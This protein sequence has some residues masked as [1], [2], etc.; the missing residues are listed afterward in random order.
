MNQLGFVLM[1]AGGPILWT[2]KK[3][4]H[5]VRSTSHE[6]YMASCWAAREVRWLRRLLCEMGQEEA[7]S[8]PTPLLGDNRAA[9]LLTRNELITPANRFYIQDYYFVK[10]CVKK[11]EIDTQKV[12]GKL[13]IS[14]P[15]TKF[16]SGAVM[17]CLGP[18]LTG[19]D[20]RELPTGD[21]NIK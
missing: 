8:T 9:I 17:K 11:K 14:D 18:W 19:W 3:H 7:V 5:V 12:S 13:N 21:S 15:L 10:E 4:T 6:E 1:L 2:S 16:V 20:D